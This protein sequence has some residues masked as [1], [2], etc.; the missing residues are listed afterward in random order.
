MIVK[1]SYQFLTD[2]IDNKRE[3]EK[4]VLRKR[5]KTDMC[6]QVFILS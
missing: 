1:P 4:Y 5:C 6:S 3:G 2:R